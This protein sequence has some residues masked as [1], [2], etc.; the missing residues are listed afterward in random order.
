MQYLAKVE[1]IICARWYNA[2]VYKKQ[3]NIDNN[4]DNSSKCMMMVVCKD[5]LGAAIILCH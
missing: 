1:A 5:K 2:Q 3:Q 4:N